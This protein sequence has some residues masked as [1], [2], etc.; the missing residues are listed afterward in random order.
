[1]ALQLAKRLK[2]SNNIVKKEFGDPTLLNE[3]DYVGC[4]LRFLNIFACAL[5]YHFLTH[6]FVEIIHAHR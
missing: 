4:Q 6:L 5:I 3:M 2:A 1:M